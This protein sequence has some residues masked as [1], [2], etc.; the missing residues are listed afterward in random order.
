MTEEVDLG[1]KIPS[2][3]PLVILNF[4]VVVIKV[5]MVEDLDCGLKIPSTL[6]LSIVEQM[7][8]VMGEDDICRI[9]V[10]LSHNIGG[11][12]RFIGSLCT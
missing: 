1:I 5:V 9:S 4:I 7:L 8:I 6:T 12:G 3:I 10:T 2:N 11:N